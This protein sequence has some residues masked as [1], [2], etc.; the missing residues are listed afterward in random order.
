MSE[1][2]ITKVIKTDLLCVGVMKY[3][4]GQKGFEAAAEKASS[5]ANP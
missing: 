2:I 5:S 4:G 1:E 3:P